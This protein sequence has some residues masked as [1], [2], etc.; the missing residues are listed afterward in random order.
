MGRKTSQ[1]KEESLRWVGRR[2]R[3][4]LFFSKVEVMK[5]IIF[6]LLFHK[7]GVLM[8]TTWSLLAHTEN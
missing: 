8:K 7:I 1:Q 5:I 6:L 2:I 4:G 3:L